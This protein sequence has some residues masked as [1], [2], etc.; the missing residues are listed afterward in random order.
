MPDLKHK[1][2]R[3]LGIYAVLIIALIFIFQAVLLQPMYT[4]SKIRSVNTVTEQIAE[5]LDTDTYLDSVY[6]L[7]RE[8]DACIRIV[9]D[10]Y[11]VTDQ[12]VGCVLNRMSPWEIQEQI[13]L[14]EE[15]GG[16]WLSILEDKH[17]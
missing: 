17:G 8:N 10:T 5:A 9:A 12:A 15:N 14:A 3:L 13:G 1:T 16:S 11:E 2:G 6:R 4:R 7:S